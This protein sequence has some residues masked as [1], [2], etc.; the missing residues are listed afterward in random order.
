MTLA[1]SKERIPV[2]EPALNGKEMEYVSDA[3]QTTWISSNGKYLE[4]F[5][6]EFST[7]VGVKHGIGVTNGTSA[8]HLALIAAGIQPGD[9][10]ILPTFTM[11][12]PA[13]A[14]C[15]TRAL[16]VFVDC[17][18][19]TWTLDVHQ[20]EKKITNKTKAIIAI[21][22]YGHPVDMDPLRDIADHHKLTLIEDA[23]EA[24]GAEYKG[25]RSGSLSDLAAFS[26]YAN[27]NITTGEGGMVVTNNDD[28]AKKCRYYKN[29]CFSLEKARN[30]IHND[31][32]FNYR[33]TNIQ[34]AIG[35]AQ[36]EKIDFYVG[37][38]RKNAESYNS[39]LKDIPHLQLPVEKPWAKNCYWMYGIV[40]DNS[41]KISRDELMAKLAE[42][43][44]ETRPF[45]APMHQQ[46][47]LK[48]YGADCSGS[49]PV[50]D[51]I[52]QRGFYL[53]SGSNLTEDQIHKVCQSL[54]KQIH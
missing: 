43:G 51:K 20:V 35:C 42:D 37:Q 10:V 47:A 49:Y 2:C 26:F 28:F 14:A 8:L 13:F 11:V 33:M 38:R 16:P 29:L 32:G 17:D 5:E 48:N 52:A 21:N 19:E 30:F 39:Q 25:Q 22:I 46:P 9:E 23:A 45:F 7:Y 40:L 54:K 27:K 18:P 1:P 3:I 24:H 44:I 53:P 34:A 6:K 15:Y 50:S 41:L 36:L 12:A 31:I 4:R